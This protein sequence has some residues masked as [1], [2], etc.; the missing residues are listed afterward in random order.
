MQWFICYLF[1]LLTESRLG[2]KDKEREK[3]KKRQKNCLLMFTFVSSVWTSLRANGQAWCCKAA[4]ER[5]YGSERLN[6]SWSNPQ[7]KAACSV[8]RMHF[9][10]FISFMICTCMSFPMCNNFHFY[11]DTFCFHYYLTRLISKASFSAL[12]RV[13]LPQDCQIRLSLVAPPPHTHTHTLGFTPP[14]HHYCMRRASFW[15]LRFFWP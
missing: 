3:K 13:Q 15:K 4:W 8:F 14:V 11:G 1:I 10:W 6:A 2:R 12:G 7:M 9:V 5:E